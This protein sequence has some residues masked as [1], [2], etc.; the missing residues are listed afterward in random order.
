[1][2]KSRDNVLVGIV[3]AF[4]V[5]VLVVGSLWLAR[6]G[7]SK[8]YPLYARFTWGANLK[9]G[10][11]VWVSG[12]TM[13]YVSDVNFQADGT[14]LVELRITSDQP[15]PRTQSRRRSSPNGLFGDVAVNFT[16][17][18]RAS[19]YAAGDTVV[20]RPAGRGDRGADGESGFDKRQE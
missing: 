7:L 17:I 19:R 11:P 3:I 15:I 18:G 14:L 6:G 5:L 20:Q 12:A 16:P 10:S 4:A 9:P 1:M 13:G 2:K 8:G